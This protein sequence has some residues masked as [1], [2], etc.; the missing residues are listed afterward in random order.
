MASTAQGGEPRRSPSAAGT[1]R[2]APS[3]PRRDHVHRLH[4]PR[5]RTWTAIPG[6]SVSLT[7]PGTLLA[8]L[9]VTSHNGNGMGAATFDTPLTGT[10]LAAAG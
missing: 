10:A 5:R 2:V 4:V 3:C 1:A 9:A 7:M 8:G 6:A